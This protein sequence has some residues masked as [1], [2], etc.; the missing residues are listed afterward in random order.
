MTAAALPEGAT[1]ADCLLF[2][3]RCSWLL[4][5]TGTEAECDWDPPRYQPA[6]G[7]GKGTTM[8]IIEFDDMTTDVT[9]ER[10]G[11]SIAVTIVAGSK[12]RLRAVMSAGEARRLARGILD[13]VGPDVVPPPAPAPVGPDE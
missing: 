9:A 3:S 5:R 1:C 13:A 10:L 12:F 4:S 6:A 8:P 7:P 2:V 11:S